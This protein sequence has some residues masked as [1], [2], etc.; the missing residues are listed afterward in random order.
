M[1]LTAQ[2]LA[3]L[4]VIERIIPEFGGARAETVDPI[5]Q[6]MQSAMLDFLKHYEHMS[7][8]AVVQN[9]YNRFRKF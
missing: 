8:E 2:D 4:N 5:A 3:A 1:K 9:R 6:V 7:P